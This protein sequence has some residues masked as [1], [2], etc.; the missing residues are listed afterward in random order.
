MDAGTADMGIRIRRVEVDGAVVVGERTVD[1]AARDERAGAIEEGD[2]AVR[3]ELDRAVVVRDGAFE[4]ASD[5]V[6]VATGHMDGCALRRGERPGQDLDETRTSRHGRIGRRL[7][8]TFMQASRSAADTCAAECGAA[9]RREGQ[10]H[11]GATH[12]W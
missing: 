1:L 11:K 8:S 4:I 10:Q 3:V 5:R 7:L 9:R 6:E 2:G 12:S